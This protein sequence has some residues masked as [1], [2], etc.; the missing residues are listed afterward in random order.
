MNPIASVIM[1][2]YN[3]G[4]FIAESIE[5]VLNQTEINFELIIVDDGSQDNS[6]EIIENY[7]EKDKRIQAVFHDKNKGIS[8]S[9]NDGLDR[10]RGKYVAL[11][12]SDDI[13]EKDKLK[14][15]LAILKKN[16]DLVVWSE[17][18]VINSK[19]LPTEK[20]FTELVKASKRKK[21]GDIFDELVCGNYICA[22]IIVK[23]ANLN[24]LRFDTDLKYINDYKFL[25]DLA[26]KYHYHYIK[27]PLLKYRLH[28]GNTIN[29][30]PYN[31]RQDMIKV[32]GHIMEKYGSK[33]SDRSK[34]KVFLA[35]A[36]AN[37]KL[38]NKSQAREN[39]YKAAKINPFEWL[40][41]TCFARYLWNSLFQRINTQ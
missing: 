5:S 30:D 15:Q 28:E 16:E 29:S 18:Q 27:E 8:F 40:N 23:R 6:R 31:W 2:S 9:Y 39:L 24:N 1:A 19:G 41:V 34:L 12:S 38:G 4:Q 10:A 3:H 21:S 11:A 14:K 32:G 20:L 35:L 26:E 36:A 13:W 7:G 33:I 22:H 25:I 37:S 17:A